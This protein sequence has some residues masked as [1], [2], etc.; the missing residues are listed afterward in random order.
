MRDINSVMA[1]FANHVAKSTAYE[2]DDGSKVYY[3]KVG[4]DAIEFLRAGLDERAALIS[5]LD[6]MNAPTHQGPDQGAHGPLVALSLAGRVAA[7]VA[8]IKAVKS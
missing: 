8:R 4:E 7:L 6:T 3:L 2:H 5:L 1:A